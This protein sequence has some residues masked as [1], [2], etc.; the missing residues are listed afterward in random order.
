MVDFVGH[1]EKLSSPH[2][3][4]WEASGI[5]LSWFSSADKGGG[6]SFL[7][8]LFLCSCRYLLISVQ[9]FCLIH[10]IWWIQPRYLFDPAEQKA[11]QLKH[12]QHVR[13]RPICIFIHCQRDKIFDYQMEAGFPVL[14]WEM[15]MEP[16]ILSWAPIYVLQ[17][18]TCLTWKRFFPWVNKHP[19]I[20]NT[21]TLHEGQEVTEVSG[22]NFPT[23]ST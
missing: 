14:T 9:F 19:L 4:Q 18:L 17:Q 6:F 15:W 2:Q 5:N 12:Q 21:K 3:G 16:L 1:G 23:L 11:K 20:R 7:F 10:H 8:T 13:S 22:C